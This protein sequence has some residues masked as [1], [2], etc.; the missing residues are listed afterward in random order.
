MRIL[1]LALADEAR[2]LVPGYPPKGARLLLRPN[3]EICRLAALADQADEFRYL[4][5]RVDTLDANGFEDLVMCHVGM[6][7]VSSARAVALRYPNLPLVFF[8]PEPTSWSSPPDWVG[9]WVTGNAAAVWTDIVRDARAGVIQRHY[10]APRRP[11]YVVPRRGPELNPKLAADS[12]SIS[13]I[14]GCCCPPA[15]R[16]LC[17][18][19]M[20]YGPE[21]NIRTP[22]EAVGEVI[23]IPGKHIRLLDDDVARFPE[24]YREVFRAVWNYRRYWTVNASVRLFEYPELV[25]VL[26]KA[27]TRVVMLND[28]FLL[29][30][31]ER[32]V[33][34]DRVVRWLYRRVKFLQSNKML[35][36]ARA[37]IWLK[38]GT[39]FEALARVLC[40]IDLDFLTT[41]F[42]E[43]GPDGDRLARV[44]Y[45][46]M[47]QKLD[48][49]SLK[50]RFF[51]VE[52]ILDRVLRRPRRVG[53]FTTLRFLLPYSL[54]CRQDFLEGL[55][56][57]AS[58]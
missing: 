40:R 27:G 9:H 23:S 50:N 45:S 16:S 29:G 19:F 13:F 31:L 28:T 25:R 35:V 48:P 52:A 42:I 57:S 6:G 22:E 10:V 54:A 20:Y 17:L 33:H 1:A 47:V 39:D 12:D 24:Y 2:R 8:G 56:D 3:L 37:T 5:E 18:D 53:F 4:D 43:S 21:L 26:A 38:P 34:D 44:T 7:L 30:R 46:P 51:A 49:G 55:P 14:Q 58:P 41:R 11:S 36:G 15:T 32:A